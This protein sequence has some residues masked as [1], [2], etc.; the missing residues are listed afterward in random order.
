MP[1]KSL[2]VGVA[3]A[4]ALSAALAAAAVAYSG[5]SSPSHP[6]ADPAAKTAPAANSGPAAKSTATLTMA[7]AKATPSAN[8]PTIS[9]ISGS[10]GVINFT[11][12]ANNVALNQ[13]QGL[14]TDPAGDL[15]VANTY[16]NQVGK[17]SAPSTW[18]PENVLGPDTGTLGW[19]GV[20]NASNAGD[21]T[22]TPTTANGQSAINWTWSDAE[23]ESWI[24]I[25][26]SLTTGDNYTASITL[27]G[28]GQVFLDF[29]DGDEDQQS[30]TVTL[31]STPQTISVSI[32][33]KTSWTPL[34]IR[35]PDGPDQS[36]LNVTAWGA[37]VVSNPPTLT[38]TASLIAGKNEWVTSYNSHGQLVNLGNGGPATSATLNT[39]SAVAVDGKGDVYIA[40]TENN[41]VRE[42]TPN[43]VIRTIAGTGRPG[44]S[45]DGGPAADAR[46]DN[47][48]GL[49][50]NAAG[51]LF[52][53][54]TVNN[55]IREVTP[56]GIIRTIAGD[57]APGRD[58]RRGGPLGG[59][60]AGDGGPAADALL[61]HPQGLSTD[62][63]GDLFIADTG[64]SV[65]REITTSGTI[66]T[67]A[68]QAG[69]FSDS[70]DGGKATSATL[71][72]PTDVAVDA[73]GDLFIADTG[74]NALREVSAAG[75]ISTLAGGNGEGNGGQGGPASSAQL[76]T[77]ES[78]AVDSSTGDVYVTSRSGVL[79]Q[80]KGLAATK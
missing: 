63:K 71:S 76:D 22:V 44:Y 42:V 27:T 14:A 17:I 35:T 75:V 65:I 62:T 25:A 9:Q 10:G 60:Y 26:P 29:Y 5:A 2:A 57:P 43:G 16:D 47:P 4:A 54:D 45:G 41:M 51:D 61:Q 78:V 30:Q 31:S 50:V 8:A 72:A 6:A 19:S 48:S 11:G 36:D 37:T 1:R 69:K 23:P 33:A 56:N 67:V 79:D 12:K 15:Y 49:A 32:T 74:N 21:S 28:H 70:G 58:H 20:Q 3:S 64:N 34:Q 55:V 18:T 73:A 38:G 13:L 59:G 40:D 66:K 68:G 80:I 39:P 24:Q 53:A 77:P 46:L 52:I 7:E